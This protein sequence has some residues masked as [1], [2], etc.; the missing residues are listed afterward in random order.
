[1]RCPPQLARDV[2]VAD[3][4]HPV[5]ERRV[6]ALRHDPEPRLPI[7]REHRLGERLHLHEPLIAQARLDDGVA[8]VAAPQRVAVR[9]DLLEQAPL[10]EHV[11]DPL[12][13]LESVQVG[14]RLGHARGVLH[15]SVLGHH[16]RHLE[17]VPQADLEVGGVV[18]G[19]HLHEPRAEGGVDHLV[20]HDRNR[21]VGDRESGHFPHEPG[22]AGILRMD[23]H[24]RVA[25]QRLGPRGG[26][27]EEG[28]G[29]AL[30]WVADVVELALRVP[31]FGFFVGQRRETVRAPM[32]HAVAAVDEPFFPQTHEHLAHRA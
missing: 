5:L 26:D 15:A 32:D 6:P 28:R 29:P 8:A 14:E 25:Q 9:L 3:V 27:R 1:M 4:L 2:P 16:Q 19:G 31:R 20:R 22:V 18:R 24:G 7:G 23:R 21:D 30:H 11:H 10:L 13:C 12:A 17:L